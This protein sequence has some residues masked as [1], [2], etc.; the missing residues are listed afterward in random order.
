MN[1]RELEA[2]LWDKLVTL[3]AKPH[4]AR[5]PDDA[6]RRSVWLDLYVEWFTPW[7]DDEDRTRVVHDLRAET[8][9]I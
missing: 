8:G 5:T 4:W 9:I 1:K 7:G 2:D 6:A 3:T